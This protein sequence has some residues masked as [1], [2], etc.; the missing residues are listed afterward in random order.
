MK[1]A[2]Q[3][4]LKALFLTIYGLPFGGEKIKRAEASLKSER[5]IAD[6]RYFKTHLCY[7]LYTFPLK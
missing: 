5:K 3:M 6:F 4:K 7:F 2:L 1:R